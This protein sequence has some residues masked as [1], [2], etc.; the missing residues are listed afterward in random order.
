MLVS[1]NK[2]AWLN[3]W[4]VEKIDPE[5]R[6]DSGMMFTKTGYRDFRKRLSDKLSSKGYTSKVTSSNDIMLS[7][8]DEEYVFLKLKYS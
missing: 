4:I 5:H 3:Q 2:N 6:D 1:L 8:P 7:I